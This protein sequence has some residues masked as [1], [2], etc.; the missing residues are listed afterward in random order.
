[1]VLSTA[2]P[3]YPT[4]VGG[5]AHR[6]STPTAH[7]DSIE[8]MAGALLDD[9]QLEQEMVPRSSRISWIP[10]GE[11]HPGWESPDNSSVQEVNKMEFTRP[12]N[13]DSPRTSSNRFCHRRKRSAPSI[14]RRSSKRKTARSKS[15]ASKLQP[16]SAQNPAVSKISAPLTHVASSSQHGGRGL[17]PHSAQRAAVPKISGPM[18]ISVPS[19]QVES[20]SALD[21]KKIGGDLGPGIQSKLDAMLAANNALKPPPPPK[22]KTFKDSLNKIKAVINDSFGNRSGR[23]KEDPARGRRLEP[24]VRS[25]NA[26]D[27]ERSEV[28]YAEEGK[29][30]VFYSMIQIS[31]RVRLKILALIVELLKFSEKITAYTNFKQKAKRQKWR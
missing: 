1:M 22:K 30:L 28:T 8:E 27:G 14:P 7:G 13:E 21:A 26:Q 31:R 5:P 29:C 24:L 9:T 12:D 11:D 10:H 18:N 3:S 25:N 4:G 2:S 6:A 15:G 19:S 17:Q 23:K 20:G 16:Q